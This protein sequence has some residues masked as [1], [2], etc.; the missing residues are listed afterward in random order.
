M[1][2]LYQLKDQY[3]TLSIVGMAKNAGKTTA[4]NYLIEEAMDE[5]M[6]LG[7][8]STGR[9][10]ET[11]DL[12]TNTDKPKVYLDTGTIVTVPVQLYE[13]AETGLE[14]IKKTRFGTAL[15][16]LLICR[17]ADSGYVQIAG[18]VNTADHRKLCEEIASLG[19]DLILID[20]AIDRKS[21]AAPET[22][23]AIILATGAVLSRTI[24]K[25]VE[26]TV[27][28]VNLY[29]MDRLEAGP[30]REM[31][32]SEIAGENRITLVKK[33]GQTQHLDLKT[34]LGASRFLDEV[35][36]DETTHVY[37]PGALTQS[38]I[39]DIHPAKLAR[40]QIVLKDP[41]RIFI[42]ALPWQQLKKR[43]FHV[44]VMEKI[45]VAAVTVNPFSPEGYSFDHEELLR[46]M[47]DGIG[48]RI[49]VVDVKLG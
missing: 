12:V 17:V 27:H 25:V 18:P 22:S 47:Q 28:I 33:G 23:D 31:I 11:C 20:G 45:E 13:L 36:D 16:E 40:V 29:S 10:G 24:R 35:I 38:V 14:I 5:G 8:T 6:F 19:V 7:V 1:G 9:D 3:K 46:A 44:C 42:G 15:G 43:G 34:G 32:A 2:L 37:I 21:I 26:E 4:L 30:V 48:D 49:P 39:A 41:T